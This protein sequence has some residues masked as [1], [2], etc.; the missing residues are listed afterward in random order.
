MQGVSGNERADRLSSKAD[1]TSGLHPDGAEELRG[2]RTCLNM[3]SDRL[4]ERGVEKR[5]G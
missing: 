2:T 4:K 5:S 1:I 3:D